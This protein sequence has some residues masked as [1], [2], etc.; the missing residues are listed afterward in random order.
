MF[1]FGMFDFAILGVYKTIPSNAMI[2]TAFFFNREIYTPF[3][4]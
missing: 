4:S 1:A 3:I 2:V